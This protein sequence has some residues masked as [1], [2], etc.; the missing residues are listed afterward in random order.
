MATTYFC[1]YKTIFFW[2]KGKTSKFSSPPNVRLS[3]CNIS[4]MYISRGYCYIMIIII[5][6]RSIESGEV[7]EILFGS[8]VSYIHVQ[9]VYD[10]L[11][12]IFIV[13]F[14]FTYHT[15]EMISKSMEH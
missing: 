14:F 13:S 2:K 6:M 5:K 11:V 15:M 7:C 12:H 3:E 9:Q 4:L 10:P 8:F 1:Q